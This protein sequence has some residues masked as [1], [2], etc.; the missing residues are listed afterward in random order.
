M[1]ETTT[2]ARG[3]AAEELCAHYLENRGLKILSRNYRTKNGE[4]D[5]IARHGEYIVFVEV[6]ARRQS[7]YGSPAETVDRRKQ[8]R[9]VATAQ[10]YLQA[11][12]ASDA[13]S[14]FDV[15]AVRGE[16]SGQQ[17]EWIQNAFDAV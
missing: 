9:L 11:K 7:R 6:R 15:M 8:A 12:G 17:I 5:L 3:A 2:G 4:I 10:H 16:N 14:R 13:A 1:K